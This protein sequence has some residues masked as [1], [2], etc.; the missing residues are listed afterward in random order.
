MKERNQKLR[1]SQN[2]YLFIG[3]KR[4]PRGGP[5]SHQHFQRLVESATA[6][7]T[8]RICTISILGKCSRLLYAEFGGHEG[9]RHLRELGL[10]EQHA[11]VY[12]WAKRV[13]VV[14]K[15]TGPTQNQYAKRGS[16]RLTVPSVDIFGIPTDAGLR[17]D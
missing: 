12:T 7:I 11:R 9:I 15:E 6:R 14:P 10:G 5:V 17:Q 16:P 13:R 4:S 3:T 1:T 8:G 2:P